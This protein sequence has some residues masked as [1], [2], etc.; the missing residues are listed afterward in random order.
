MCGPWGKK[1][2][3]GIAS[4]GLCTVSHIF[5]QEGARK[6]GNG[7]WIDQV[8]IVISYVFRGMRG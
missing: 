4:K 3:I 5:M 2:V 1:G 8:L 6:A 7:P